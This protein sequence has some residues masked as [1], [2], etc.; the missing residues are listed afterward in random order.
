MSGPK[1]ARWRLVDA[2]TPGALSVGEAQALLSTYFAKIDALTGRLVDLRAGHPSLS[3]EAAADPGDRS[4][5]QTA[6]DL[7]AGLQRVQAVHNRLLLAV[8][9]AIARIELAERLRRFAQPGRTARPADLLGSENRAETLRQAALQE[10]QRLLPGGDTTTEA[11]VDH[12]LEEIAL[13]GVARIET[14]TKALKGLIDKSNTTVRERDA[15]RR[16]RQRRS[17]SKVGPLLTGLLGA[18]GGVADAVR[19][20]LEAAQR[21]EVALTDTMVQRAQAAANSTEMSRRRQTL[22]A[23]RAAA[24]LR[25]ALGALGY[26]VGESFETS[27]AEGGQTLLHKPETD[28]VWQ[29]HAC[30]LTVDPATSQL[31]LRIVRF[32]DRPQPTKDEAVEDAAVE[33]LWCREFAAL[34]ESLAARGLDLGLLRAELPGARPVTRLARTRSTRRKHEAIQTSAHAVPSK[35]ST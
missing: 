29:D 16:Q 12:A 2:A 27:F 21:G 31:D 23:Q 26:R 5:P 4:M 1:S 14:A 15:G 35:P 34:T 20:E 6:A 33:R 8:E 13:M 19:A 28:R 25:D 9:E 7:V 3:I 10:A 22:A 11:A 30:Q 32:S 24:I 18:T 17:A